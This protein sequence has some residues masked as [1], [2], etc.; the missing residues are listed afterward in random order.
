MNYYYVKQ[1][2]LL[3]SFGFLANIAFGQCSAG[4]CYTQNGTLPSI[5]LT[6][7]VSNNPQASACLDPASNAGT[8]RCHEVIFDASIMLAD[9]CPPPTVEFKGWQ[10]C[11]NGRGNWEIFDNQC[12][13]LL[14][15]AA[16]VLYTINMDP[17]TYKDTII[18]CTKSNKANLSDILFCRDLCVEA[19]PVPV[20]VTYECPPGVGPSPLLPPVIPADFVVAS[21]GD[22][23]VAT[24]A[25]GAIVYDF[26][27]TTIETEAIDSNNGGTGCLGD[28][29]IVTRTYTVYG[30]KGTADEQIGG[31]WT[32]TYTWED[33]TKPTFVDA[34][35]S[36]TLA[37]MATI[38]TAPTVTWSDN[39]S[40]GGSAAFSED[41]YT[42]DECTGYSIT[43]RWN[44]TDDCGNV[45]D[46]VIQ[47][48]TFTPCTPPAVDAVNFDASCV[49]ATIDIMAS[50][51]E[52][53]TFDYILLSTDG[54]AVTPD[55]QAT[56]TFSVPDATTVT[57]AVIDPMTGCMSSTFVQ[58]FP[59]PLPIELLHF[60]ADYLNG[61]VELTWATATELNNSHFLI[62]RSQDG[63][64]F[65]NIARVEGNN[66]TNI[67]SEYSYL[68]KSFLCGPT[69]YRLVQ[70][71]YD[72]RS[73]T[74][75]IEL[76][77][78]PCDDVLDVKVY[79]AQNANQINLNIYSPVDDFAGIVIYDIHGR[80]ILSETMEINSGNNR[81][82][83]DMENTPSRVLYAQVRLI[84]QPD[85]QVIPFVRINPN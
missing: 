77:K 6:A 25:L 3:V 80:K 5:T 62:Q 68:D 60:N 23:E 12:N 15:S 74:S 31:T 37:C 61:H 33:T 7:D 50:G 67:L 78:I 34:P 63:R 20:A 59:C 66:T 81:F 30:D 58:N 57:I 72:G 65:R 54:I 38:P 10:G 1:I 11:G 51:G 44:A 70:V 82:L 55:T 49:S 39:C 18:F 2:L 45:A 84:N 69:Y 9:P 19:P 76:V 73:T 46:E 16:G 21:G 24:E 29:Y 22:D 47:T 40:L 17:T 27:C 79:P 26:H 32:E 48:I 56:G 13:C 75:K 8:Q 64:N 28:P 53:G 71:D 36:T 83:L 4:W 42:V 35:A 43:R 14:P 85:Y 52:S 41:A